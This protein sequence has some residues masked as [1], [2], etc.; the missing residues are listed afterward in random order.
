LPSCRLRRRFK[1]G[2]VAA[3]HP[4]ILVALLEAL[5]AAGER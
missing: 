5:E 2:R 3:S 4:S 1:K